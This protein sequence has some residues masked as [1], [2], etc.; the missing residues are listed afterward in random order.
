MLLKWIIIIS[1]LIVISYFVIRYFLTNFYL[2]KSLVKSPFEESD[3]NFLKCRS[4][5]S[6]LNSIL[7]YKN[8]E[9]L[10][11]YTE[12]PWSSKKNNYIHDLLTDRY[13]IIDK[14]HY[15]FIDNPERYNIVV[16]KDIPIK[17]FNSRY[18]NKIVFI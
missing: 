10:L 4:D 2:N 11:F 18:N 12:V 9:Y 7:N 13:Y 6:S 17:I 5:Q 8:K 15:Y 16:N 14:D 3:L 1:I